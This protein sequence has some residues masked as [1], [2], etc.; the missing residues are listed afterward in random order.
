MERVT[1]PGGYVE[2]VDMQQFP[3]TESPAYNRVLKAAADL[4][5]KRGMQTGVEHT[6]KGYLEQAGLQRIQERAFHVG[7]G[8]QQSREQRLLISDLLAGHRNLK[9]ALVKLGYF[10]EAEFDELM[11]GEEQELPRYGVYLPVIYTFGRK[12]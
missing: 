2:M 12:P 6:L 9:G 4:V 1:R 11:H 10:S 5:Q 3:V 8:R 7:T